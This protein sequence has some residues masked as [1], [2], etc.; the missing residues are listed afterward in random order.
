MEKKIDIPPLQWCL[1]PLPSISSQH[2][3]SPLA[4]DPAPSR[5]RFVLEDL[6]KSG[7]YSGASP[8]QISA[9]RQAARDAAD[10]ELEIRDL[11]ERLS[12]ARSRFRRLTHEVLPAL[13]VAAGEVEFTLRGGGNLP[14]KIVRLAPY[15]EANVAASWPEERRRAGFSALEK[16]DADWM[17]KSTVTAYFKQHDRAKAR[18]LS[19][20][21][22][23]LGVEVEVRESVHPGQLK[24]WLKRQ[25]EGGGPIPPLDLI[26]AVIGQNAI[27][28]DASSK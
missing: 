25:V 12:E 26:G 8:E 16:L 3:E 24:A 4:A 7:S 27:L 10:A 20:I 28:S 21:C 1:V 2:E 5:S 17:I 23:N 18:E 19:R 11:E 15:Y 22:E 9:V 14:D 13:M 6:A